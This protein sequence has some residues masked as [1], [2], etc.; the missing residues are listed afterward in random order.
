M[1]KQI[2]I[3]PSYSNKIVFTDYYPNRKQF[4][5]LFIHYYE[6]TPIVYETLGE[7]MGL[8]L[9]FMKD[10]LLLDKIKLQNFMNDLNWISAGK[11]RNLPLYNQGLSLALLIIDDNK[12]KA[13]RYGR[14]LMGKISEKNIQP[15]GPE[16]DNF[17]IKSLDRLA[18]L[19][20][21]SEDNY[22]EF[23][24]IELTNNEKFV[25][26]ES[27]SEAAFRESITSGKQFKPKREIYQ[28]LECHRK[29]FKKK[30]LGII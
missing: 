3:S 7:I 11:L 13:V 16:W 2:A 27:D 25:I 26:L 8:I 4:F 9:N 30:L 29:E 24:E 6:D 21:Q 15:I 20:L 5:S 10:N 23:F 1:I 18:L 22:P 14:M 28:I 19:G 12:I 17:S